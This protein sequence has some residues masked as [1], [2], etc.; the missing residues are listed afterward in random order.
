MPYY[1]SQVISFSSPGSVIESAP[2]PHAGAPAASATSPPPNSPHGT[3]SPTTSEPPSPAPPERPCSAPSYTQTG[4][5]PIFIEQGTQKTGVQDNWTESLPCT[6]SQGTS[7]QLDELVLGPP[8]DPRLESIESCQKRL[9]EELEGVSK[10]VDSLQGER[11]EPPNAYL[12]MQPNG[13]ALLVPKEEKEEDSQLESSGREQSTILQTTG[14][15]LKIQDL[16]PPVSSPVSDPF[17]AGERV[18]VDSR[19]DGWFYTADVVEQHEGGYVVCVKVSGD[20]VL[21]PMVQI[22]PLLSSERKLPEVYADQRVLAEH[23]SYPGC[24]APGAVMHLVEETGS[25]MVRLY[26]EVVCEVQWNRIQPVE[27]DVCV[28]LSEL[29]TQRD[30]GWM[31]ARVVSRRDHTG[32]FYAGQVVGKSWKTR[33][34]MVQYSDGAIE[35]QS[36]AHIFKA[37]DGEG[38]GIEEGDCALASPDTGLFMPGEVVERAEERVVVRFCHG[39]EKEIELGELIAISRNCYQD[40]FLYISQQQNGGEA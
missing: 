13:Q 30:S 36:L 35:E 37:P 6:F 21:L 14:P 22:L 40:M 27:A 33:N 3:Q 25:A 2:V 10:K 1:L 16:T 11:E 15:A 7:T 39:E 32:V 9:L 24:Y 26:D 19:E 34:F 38:Q 28:A 12:V 5:R 17:Y 31:T 4:A 8:S 20:H 18:L 29:A 23:P